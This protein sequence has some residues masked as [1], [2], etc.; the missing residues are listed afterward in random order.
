MHVTHF[1][2]APAYDPPEHYD[3]DCLRLQGREAG[4]SDTL[5][6]GM[7]RILPGGHTSLD[8][9][10]LEK[11]YF[12]V[13]GELTVETADGETTLAPFVFLPH[14]AQRSAGA[15]E[16]NQQARHRS[17]FHAAGRANQ[18]SNACGMPG[19]FIEAHGPSLAI[20]KQG[21]HK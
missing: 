9:S 16:Q 7:S 17:A 4:P 19:Y 11:I 18:L 20:A 14:R 10:P 1:D 15:Q 8:A 21:T 12:V 3:M 6:L 2:K 5:W 13:E